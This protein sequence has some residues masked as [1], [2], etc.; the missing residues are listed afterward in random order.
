MPEQSKH[1]VEHSKDVFQASKTRSNNRGVEPS[2][3]GW[4]RTINKLPPKDPNTAAT[5]RERS[6]HVFE[7]KKVRNPLHCQTMHQPREVQNWV[8][9]QSHNAFEHAS[10]RWKNQTGVEQPKFV[11]NNPNLCREI[12]YTGVDPKQIYSLNT[13]GNTPNR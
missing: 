3:L 12:H 1:V 8:D 13:Y 4:A 10:I 9:Q 6:K 11:S 7:R 5:P 2:T